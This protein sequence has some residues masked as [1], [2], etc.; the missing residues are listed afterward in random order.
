MTNLE[1]AETS[2]STYKDKYKSIRLT[3]EDG[4][5]EVHLHTDDG[6]LRWSLLAHNELEDAFL[7]IG[8]DRAND[9]VILTGTGD[10]FCGPAIAPGQ[11]PNRKIMTPESYDPIFWESRQLLP[12]LLNI[13]A[14]VISVINGP[15]VRHAEIPLLGDIVLASNTAFIQDTAH[16]PGGMVPGDGMHIVMPLIMGLTRGRYFLLTGQK[17]SAE[18]ALRIGLVNE[19]LPPEGLLGRAR[20]LARE[21]LLQPKL[22]R[23]YT[24]IALTEEIRSRMQGLLG[25]G[26]ALEGMA[27]MKS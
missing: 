23:R 26:L 24:R 2:F 12:N 8:R 13:E 25:Y 7:E 21:L 5:L 20:E 16:F 11:H 19:V 27:R 17:I 1:R 3:R 9:V 14:P 22:V 15:A 18:E 4:I 10:E 6:P